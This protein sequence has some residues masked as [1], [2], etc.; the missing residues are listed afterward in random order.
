MS[1][2]ETRILLI[3]DQDD[4]A[5]LVRALVEEGLRDAP[6]LTIDH[7]T[8]GSE[9]LRLLES[10]EYDI[11]LLDYRLGDGIN[12]LGVLEAAR[13]N[14]TETSFVMLT[15]EGDENVAVQAM[16][17]GARDY[18]R[19]ESISPELLRST[20]RHTLAL[21]REEALRK[22]AQEELQRAM[23]E[24]EV[25]VHEV[26]VANAHLRKLGRVK[27]DF[28]GSISHEL[29]TPIANIKLAQQLLIA[30]PDAQNKYLATMR[31]ETERLHSLI[32]DLLNVASMSVEPPALDLVTCD[33]NTI[34][35]LCVA[36]RTL[37]A[38]EKGLNLTFTEEPGLP[39][40]Q[41]DKRQLERVLGIL[42]TNALSY[43]PDGGQ[44]RVS[45]LSQQLD[46]DL[47][48]GFSV[49]DTG[50]GID[51][52]EQ[53]RLF[54]R[55]FRGRAAL[56]RGVP[57]TGLGLA[58]A[59]EIVE[60]HGGKLEVSSEGEPGRGAA[61]TVWLPAEEP[62]SRGRLSGVAS[63]LRRKSS[64]EAEPAA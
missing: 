21:Q 35:L 30:H 63:R 1:E 52:E 25:R 51:A 8:S 54:E 60:E 32:E 61:L 43:T 14:G 64:R 12:G 45:T 50:L 11:C 40:I 6:R 62:K 2:Q 10:D 37:L 41:A 55:F 9:G 19:K 22:Q 49:K 7:A 42:L 47:W 5:A 20:L 16:K 31:R 44:I 34:V 38:E 4:H 17:N 15:G 36:D 23:D 26:N 13:S 48:I 3:E 46:G 29:R 33:M 58:T 27:D 57:G 24:L 18:L 28:V 39:K 59:R 53:E 56:E